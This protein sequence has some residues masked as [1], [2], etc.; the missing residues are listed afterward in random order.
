MR[1]EVN[2][3]VLMGG[4]ARRHRRSKMRPA[5]AG[6]GVAEMTRLEDP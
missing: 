5:N 1:R 3:R 4:H 6:I 2:G